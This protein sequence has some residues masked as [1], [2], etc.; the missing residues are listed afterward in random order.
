MLERAFRVL[1]DELPGGDEM[2][3]HA[4]GGVL[5][6]SPQVPAH[7]SVQIG[8]ND[9]RWQLGLGRARDRDALYRGAT[10]LRAHRSFAAFRAAIATVVPLTAAGRAATVALLSALRGGLVPPAPP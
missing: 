5:L 10:L 6:Q 1:V 3:R 4:L 9:V 7:L 8:S 2:T